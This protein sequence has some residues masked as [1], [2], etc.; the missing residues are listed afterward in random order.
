M[1]QEIR[2]TTYEEF[3]IPAVVPEIPRRQTS[4][5]HTDMNQSSVD[6]ALKSIG[7]LKPGESAYLVAGEDL[8]ETATKCGNHFKLPV[9]LMPPETMANSFCWAIVAAKGSFFSCPIP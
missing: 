9:I 8:R 4:S 6:F 7:A 1:D 2:L 5:Y 3:T